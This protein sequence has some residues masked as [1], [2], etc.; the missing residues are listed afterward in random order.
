GAGFMLFNRYL[1]DLAPQ[2]FGQPINMPWFDF[3]AT[4]LLG[5]RSFPAGLIN[6]IFAAL[7]LPLI[8]LFLWFLLYILLRRDWLAALAAA[9][10]IAVG[11]SLA[12]KSL[13]AIPFALI[14]GFLLVFVI[15]RYGLLALI[16]TFAF[17]HLTVFFPLTS[18]FTAWYAADF[19]LALIISIALAVF[20]F[21]TSL[22]GQP[23][24][25]GAIPDE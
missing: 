10:L 14:T 22:A 12:H 19:V 3:P 7:L 6:Q 2:W 8:L 23:L 24:F 1:S 13:A 11:A 4:Q 17:N 18:D 16:S 21:Y 5:I 20:G 15:Y 25:G 9:L